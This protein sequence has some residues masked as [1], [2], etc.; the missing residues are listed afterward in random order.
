[1]E[2]QKQYDP[3]QLTHEVYRLLLEKGLPVEREGDL[4]AAIEG[5]SKILLWLGLDPVIPADIASYRHLDL[6][7]LSY[8]HRIHGD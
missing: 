4:D 3:I 1:M 6:D 2:A 8:V 5:A 7:H